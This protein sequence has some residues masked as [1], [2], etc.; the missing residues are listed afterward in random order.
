MK[1]LTQLL[2]RSCRSRSQSNEVN[3]SASPTVSVLNVFWVFCFR[4][5]W[6]S[7][8]SIMYRQN[9]FSSGKALRH[10][11]DTPYN[12]QANV[13]G[14]LHG[15]E[16]LDQLCKLSDHFGCINCLNF[17]QNGKLLASGSDDLKIKVWNWARK[18]VVATINTSHVSNIFQAKFIDYDGL[19]GGFQLVSSDQSG[20]V[21]QYLVGPCGAVR[22]DKLLHG[23]PRAVHKLGLP[24]N[25][26]YEVLSVGEDCRVMLIDLR[27]GNA[28]RLLRAKCPLY[29][30]ACHPLDSNE[31]CLGGQDQYVRVYDRRSVKTAVRDLCPKHL[32]NVSF[33]F[34][35]ERNPPQPHYNQK[36]FA[37]FSETGP[38]PIC[39]KCRVQLYWLGN[40]GF[41][42]QRKCLLIRQPHRRLFA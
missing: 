4:Y 10:T 11:V 24:S 31:F 33:P 15:V 34:E 25:R 16:R 29:S 40:T 9:G 37:Y 22:V 12:F 35:R 13:R 19:E 14:S 41:V 26:P 17:S 18:R 20:A 1:K 28:T 36:M 39:D 2:R 8:P 32:V 5:A 27:E 42:F 30:I 6:H 23:S 3:V 7:V 21:R 38:F